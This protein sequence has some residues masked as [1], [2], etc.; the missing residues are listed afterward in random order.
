V[1]SSAPRKNAL[2]PRERPPIIRAQRLRLRFDQPSDIMSGSQVECQASHHFG[3]V[4]H[5][6]PLRRPVHSET[7]VVR[8][9]GLA[10]PRFVDSG[11]HNALLF[12]LLAL[13]GLALIGACSATAL[14]ASGIDHLATRTSSRRCCCSFPPPLWGRVRV[15]VEGSGVAPRTMH[16][17]RSKKRYRAPHLSRI[18]PHNGR[19]DQRLPREVTKWPLPETAKS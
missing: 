11:R 16:G 6:G 15:G 8:A 17:A 13:P 1:S 12:G 9:I 4:V 5:V 7:Q 18:V 19:G 14:V 2:S 10:S 3:S